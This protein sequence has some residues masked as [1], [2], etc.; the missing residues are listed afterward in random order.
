ME[1]DYAYKLSVEKGPNTITVIFSDKPLTAPLFLT[2]PAERALTKAEELEL[3]NFRQQYAAG[4]SIQVGSQET[5][6]TRGS[7]AGN[8][9]LIFEMTLTGR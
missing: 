9:P 3:A 2:Q 1:A 7:A 6:I 5:I 8:N 4:V